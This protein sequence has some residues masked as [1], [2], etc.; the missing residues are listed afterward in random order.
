MDVTKMKI[1]T[2]GILNTSI[3]TCEGEQI[4]KKISLEEA[5]EL[6]KIQTTPKIEEIKT[7]R[8]TVLLNKLLKLIIIEKS[9]KGEVNEK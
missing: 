3:L 5:R 9:K 6:L 7:N 8:F 1:K 2:I 4:L